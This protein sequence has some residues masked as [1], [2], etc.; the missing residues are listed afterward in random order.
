L[1]FIRTLTEI[2]LVLLY[3]LNRF[4]EPLTQQQLTDAAQV[5]DGF[6][7][8]DAVQALSEL[9]STAHIEDSGDGAERTY[10][11]TDKG[12]SAAATT[13]SDVPYSVRLK[14]DANVDALRKELDLLRMVAIV[15][16]TSEQ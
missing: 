12:R 4:T 3:I 14:L 9:L 5:D 2:K 8:F 16:K 15:R 1:G 7:Y 6:T 13:A 10:S 11:S